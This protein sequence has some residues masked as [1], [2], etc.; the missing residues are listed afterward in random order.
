MKELTLSFTGTDSVTVRFSDESTAPMAFTHT[1]SDQDRE[2]I[3]GCL[4]SY[5]T[6]DTTNRDDARADRIAGQRLSWGESLYDAVFQDG[7]A[8]RLFQAFYDTLNNDHGVMTIDTCE[9]TVLSLPWEFL[10]RDGRHLVHENPTISIRR[11]LTG[12]GERLP[13][14][15]ESGFF[16]RTVELRNIERHFISG[17]RCITMTGFGG[18][19]KTTL[20][21]E[22]GR[23]LLCTGMFESCCFISFATYQGVDP[24]AFC[25]R[26]LSDILYRNLMDA[27]TVIEA[28]TD[29][30]TLIILD[31]VE[32]LNN[33]SGDLQTALL[34][35]T[36]AW[37]RA[38]QSRVLITTRQNRLAYPDYPEAGQTVHRYLDLGGLAEKDAV[39]YVSA[40]WRLPPDPA[41]G[42]HVPERHG[43]VKLFN[44][45]AGHPMCVRILAY[46]LKSRTVAD[47]DNRLEALLAE[48]H[49]TGPE[50]N[51]RVCLD[52][53]LER[54]SS[55]MAAL[56][57]SLGVFQGGAME[58]VLLQ[59]TGLAPANE[60]ME[61]AKS[62]KMLEALKTKNP[63]TI[64]RA[65][66]MNIPDGTTLPD[67]LVQQLLDNVDETIVT[68][69]KERA[70]HT[71]TDQGSSVDEAN[72][73]TLRDF[74]EAIGLIRMEPLAEVGASH[75]SFHPA[76]AQALWERILEPEREIFLK[77][78]RAVYYQLAKSLHDLNPQEPHI[79]RMVAKCE[80]PNLLVAVRASFSAGDDHAV[81]FV[82]RITT[83]L[84]DFGFLMDRDDL[85][86]L[87]EEVA[88]PGTPVWFL[89]R[90]NKGEALFHAGR[91]AEAEA[92]FRA[93]LEILEHGESYERCVTLGRLGQC[94]ERSARPEDAVAV[95]H[96]G[97]AMVETL[98]Q[99][100][101]VRHL[102]GNLQGDL[103]NSLMSK[104]D[105]PGARAAYETSLSIKKDMGDAR[106]MAA[107]A[108]QLGT[109]AGVEGDFTEAERRYKEALKGFQR[110]KEPAHEAVAHH[111]L[112][113][114]YKEAKRYDKAEAAYRESARIEESQ[115]DLIGA[116]GTYTNLAVTM[117][118]AERPAEAET[119][120]R[121]AM[122]HLEHSGQKKALSDVISNLAALL[123]ADPNRLDEARTLA[124]QAL[125][126][127]KTMKSGAAEIWKTYHILAEVTD[128]QGQAEDAREYRRLSRES[129][130]GFM[131]TQHQVRPILLQ[132]KPV[133]QK[134]VAACEGD[135]DARRQVEERMDSFRKGKWKIVDAIHAIWAGERDEDTL[136]KPVD[137]QDGIIIRA[138]LA[139]LRG[140]DVFSAPEN[141]EKEPEIQ[142]DDS[143]IQ[144]LALGA[145]LP[146][147]KPEARAQAEPWLAQL[148]SGG[149]KALAEAIK[150]L[151]NGESNRGALCKDIGPK[152]Q[153]VINQALHWIEHP[154]ELVQFMERSKG[155]HRDR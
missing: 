45:V 86:R 81:D 100:P 23:W 60:N 133:I 138:I 64:A 89:S 136:I 110:L 17:A 65:M 76:L 71:P 83:F 1:L 16:G 108:G 139:T 120:F 51:L 121:R 9:A 103:G 28:L 26:A 78:H 34:D 6:Q 87:A 130:D 117:I 20:A 59:V 38:G 40:L 39:A 67:D 84:G 85:N 10:A 102:T 105:Y 24:V 15:P 72:W 104:G 22:A 96:Q 155:H 8:G 115:G 98:E 154:K 127:R 152:E 91:Y 79:T 77:R 107:L 113:N 90:S 13:D 124:E 131:G 4:D 50:T 134:V 62:R 112:G 44:R 35:A 141:D 122:G 47:V 75:V 14:P 142:D 46:Q 125:A 2:D 147:L 18:Q 93:I 82:D 146:V 37:S 54:L 148:I 88:K 80:L 143:P 66:G 7:H 126:I 109:L 144:Q 5:D 32:S 61:M 12:V 63:V 101:H 29:R 111:Q 58:D 42:I 43:L 95:F 94:L 135:D 21:A 49:G 11:K 123:Q 99:N 132:F 68:L 106:G 31:N 97:L 149:G 145:A 30:P 56:L 3:R 128:K 116:A 119:W 137:Y 153:A 57:R 19:G 114:V 129:R 70:S 52:L 69:E 74:L 33:D 151:W 55:Q 118:A 41:P 92:E 36:A 48:A 150:R 140:E 27:Q 73:P 53:S 25:T